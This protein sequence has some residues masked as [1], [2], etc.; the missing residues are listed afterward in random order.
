MREIKSAVSS[1]P[2]KTVAVG[3]PFCKSMLQSTPE[4]QDSGVA[5]KDVAELMLENLERGRLE[6]GSSTARIAVSGD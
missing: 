4:A 5:I 3:C 1:E 2:S 6:V